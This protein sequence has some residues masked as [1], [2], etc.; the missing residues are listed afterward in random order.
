MV[1]AHIY[2]KGSVQGVGFRYTSQ[3]FAVDLGLKGWVKN[4]P[5]GRVELLAEGSKDAVESLL[6]NL[7]NHFGG[8][9]HEVQKVF[10]EGRHEFTEFKIAY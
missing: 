1:Q 6:Q 4:L 7:S 2:F 8:Y 3:R 10:K 9:I 5:D